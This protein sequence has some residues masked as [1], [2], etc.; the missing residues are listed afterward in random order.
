MFSQT[1]ICLAEF[2]FFIC[3]NPQLN[4]VIFFVEIT[5]HIAGNRIVQMVYAQGRRARTLGPFKKHEVFQINLHFW[6][7]VLLHEKA[8]FW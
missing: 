7:L 6:N 8:M 2:F 1:R 5:W 3:N 4:L